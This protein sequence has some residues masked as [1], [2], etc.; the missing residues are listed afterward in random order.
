MMDVIFMTWD[1]G[2]MPAIIVLLAVYATV[3]RG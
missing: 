2:V 1:A 3:F